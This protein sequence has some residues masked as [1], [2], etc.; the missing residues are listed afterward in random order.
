MSQRMEVYDTVSRVFDFN[1]SARA[2]GS[3]TTSLRRAFEYLASTVTVGTSFSKVKFL[4]IS[5][6]IS[7]RRKPVMTALYFIS[8]NLLFSRI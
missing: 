1:S 5:V 2:F 8:Q 3:A 4:Q 7:L 6:L